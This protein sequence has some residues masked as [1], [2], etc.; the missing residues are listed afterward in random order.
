MKAE[1]KL[2]WKDIFRYWIGL[3]A[4][5]A[6]IAIYRGTNGFK[7]EMSWVDWL[8]L[9][10][11]ASAFGSVI[12]TLIANGVAKG[13]AKAKAAEQKALATPEPIEGEGA[14]AKFKRDYRKAAS[15]DK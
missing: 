2:W 4:L 10:F 7:D 8:I 9:T 5:G 1:N 14:W 11:I 13:I 15:G 12:E 3:V 6:L